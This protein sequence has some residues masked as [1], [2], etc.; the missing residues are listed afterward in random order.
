M[1]GHTNKLWHKNRNG[2]HSIV[3]QA[4]VDGRGLQWDVSAG[5]LGNVHDIRDV[6]EQF[7]PHLKKGP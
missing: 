6:N 5:F 1:M 7:I 3:L 2:W 4:V